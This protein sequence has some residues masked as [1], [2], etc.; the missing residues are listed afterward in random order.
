ML[1]L[2]PP[3]ATRG[4]A[5][6]GWYWRA[7]D[8]A[9]GRAIAVLC[10]VCRPRRGAAW[11]VA[12]IA[13]HPGGVVR[14]GLVDG[15]AGDPGGFGAWGHPLLR[16]TAAELRARI[17]DT[18]VDLRLRA[19]IVAP[20]ASIGPA[21]LLPGLPQYWHAHVV[22][23]SADGEAVVAGE[24]WDLSGARVY[25]EKNW[26]PDFAAD[27]WWGQGFL[28]HQVGVSF[29]G[30]RVGPAAPTAIVV[31]LGPRMLRLAP[32]LARVTVATA[33]GAWRVRARGPRLAVEVE[34]EGAG[35]AP[36]LLPVPDV[37]DRRCRMRSA[38]H[39][40]GRLRLV[41]R[42]GRRLRFSGETALAGLERGL[43]RGAP[44]A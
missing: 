37:E 17:G 42:E 43:P 33:P 30:G 6:E 18:A 15:A 24:R 36:H 4:A 23:A 1:D 10:G 16:G 8:E 7:A 29:A 39:L 35:V 31:R 3:V 32:P 41:V 27:W 38:Q 28:E 5:L 14:W 44:P 9:T 13:A 2:R 26:G 20:R 25:A 11:A 12:A 21:Q 22:D 19:P 34:G 40:A